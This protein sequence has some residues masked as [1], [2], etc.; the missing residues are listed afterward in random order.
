MARRRYATDEL[1]AA[2]PSAIERE[3]DRVPLIFVLE[4]VRAAF[5]VGLV[6]RLADCLNIQALWL[7]GIT[8]YPGVSQRADNR[9]GKTGVGGSLEVLPWRYFPDPVP[10]VQRMKARGW[11]VTAVEQTVDSMPWNAAE[12]DL[13][14]LLVFGH[15]RDG[16]SPQLLAQ[17]DSTVRLPVRGITNSLNV[18][19]CASALGYAILGQSGAAVGGAPGTGVE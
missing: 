16:V 17:A 10:A 18:A 12:L 9:L 5:N 13:P 8:A 7:A 6:F 2:R 1:V 11:G 4:S 15:E 3:A 19:L 14:R